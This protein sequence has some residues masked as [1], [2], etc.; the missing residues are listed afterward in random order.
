MSDDLSVDTLLGLLDEQRREIAVR[1]GQERGSTGWLTATVRLDAI[2]E[3]I[4]R[5]AALGPRREGLGTGVEL[6][7]D[8]RPADDVAFRRRV[9]ESFRRAIVLVTHERLAA[10]ASQRLNGVDDRIQASQRMI[11]QAEATLR[12]DYPAATI[13]VDV[14]V[15]GT[16]SEIELLGIRADREG[17]V[18]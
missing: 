14:G 18:A 2:N 7:L 4:M 8:S 10:R 15:E 11:R 9:V 5:Y 1:S 3:R 13:W 17:R 16:G 6:E 12:R